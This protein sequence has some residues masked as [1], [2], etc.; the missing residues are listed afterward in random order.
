VHHL[1]QRL[2][3][4]P[5]FEKT[6]HAKYDVYIRKHRGWRQPGGVKLLHRGDLERICITW[7]WDYEEKLQ[8]RVVRA[9]HDVVAN[10]TMPAT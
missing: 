9:S 3:Y 2:G 5:H 6:W 8:E 7:A 4:I 10:I 1:I